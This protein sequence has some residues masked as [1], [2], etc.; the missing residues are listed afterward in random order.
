MYLGTV[1]E[2]GP[3]EA[4]FANPG[5]PYTAAL[6]RAVPR[7]DPARSGAARAPALRG[8]PPRPV[9]PPRGCP[10]RPRCPCAVAIYSTEP[11]RIALPGGRW[12]A[13]HF[14]E[15][16]AAGAPLPS[17]TEDAGCVTLS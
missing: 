3:T 7:P 6:L 12:S 10:F 16:V 11:P 15:A 8:D 1:V 4:V 5:H 2:S 14:A 13:C 9:S 17:Q